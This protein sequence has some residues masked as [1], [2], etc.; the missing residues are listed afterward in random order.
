[1][2]RNDLMAQLAEIKEE[3]AAEMPTMDDGMAF[4]IA[5]SLLENDA[6]LKAAINKHIKVSDVRGWLANQI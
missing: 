6:E 5:D 4:E 3:L 2:T 1:M